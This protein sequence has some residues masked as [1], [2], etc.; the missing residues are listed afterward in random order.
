[1][2]K[3]WPQARQ[4]EFG[5]KTSGVATPRPSP[6][7]DAAGEEVQNAKNARTATLQL[8][9]VSRK[10]RG[11]LASVRKRPRELWGPNDPACRRGCST[12][13]RLSQTA[14]PPAACCKDMLSEDRLQSLRYVTFLARHPDGGPRNVNFQSARRRQ[15]FRKR[16]S[17]Q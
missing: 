3:G 17:S 9:P 10:P 5:K 16:N 1:M 6:S 12:C 13:L 2:G 15:I 4:V 11:G 14:H 8:P 7:K